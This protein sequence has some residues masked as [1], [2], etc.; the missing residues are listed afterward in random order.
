MTEAVW[1]LAAIVIAG[2]FLGTFG[3][4]MKRMA[5]LCWEAWWLVYAFV[6]MI[7]VPWA[8]AS[9]AVPDLP[10]LLAASVGTGALFW[11]ALFGFLWGLGGI[12]FGIS[13]ERV[14]MALTYGIVMGLSSAAGSLAPFF[15]QAGAMAEPAAPYVLAAVLIMV[16][17]VAVVAL[18]GVR[19][20]RLG[21]GKKGSR[22]GLPIA[23]FSGVTSSFLAIG[24]D[25]AAP[26]VDTAAVMGVRSEQVSLA[27]W[28]VVCTG[29]FAMNAAYCLY[30]LGRNRS[31]KSFASPGNGRA[32]VWAAVTGVLWF[33]SFG[34]SGLG[35][36]MMGA[37]GVSI[38]WSMLLGVGLSVS[39]LWSVATGEWRGARG[40][41]RTMLAGAAIVMGAICLL[42][43]SNSL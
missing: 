33:A 14:G 23:I 15:R 34:I 2:F 40:P 31:W 38:G 35:M 17:G 29:A 36:Q 12:T 39:T 21:A 22:G 25:L 24:F 7:A 16:G 10:R 13:V 19:R 26:I 27:R 30:L 11:G 18:A 43:Y 20:E 8:W 4:G 37:L 41:F 3:L 9:L 1:P 5:P 32:Y 42:G 6:A 28:A